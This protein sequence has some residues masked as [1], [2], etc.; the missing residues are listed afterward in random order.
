[1][2]RVPHL[3]TCLVLAASSAACTTVALYEPVSADISLIAETSPLQKPS[4]AF[5]KETREKGLATGEASLASLTDILTGKDRTEGAYWRLIGADKAAP[6]AV[7]TRIR[8][9]MKASANGI[10][11]L[12]KLAQS[13]VMDA[14]PTRADVTEF[15]RALIHARQARDSL[16]DAFV[17]VNKRS[18]SEY[19]ISLELAQLDE[20]LGRARRMADELAASRAPDMDAAAIGR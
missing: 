2:S 8:N 12:T 15:E 14:A 5:C 11:A 9:D 1:L 7:V 16:S 4:D 3:I 10:D 20:S 17:Q 18:E 6:A 19:Q 13:L